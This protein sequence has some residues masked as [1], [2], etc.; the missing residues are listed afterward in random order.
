MEKK[1][2]E[3]RKINPIFVSM[4]IAAIFENLKP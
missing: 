4:A 3:K 1:N 2:K